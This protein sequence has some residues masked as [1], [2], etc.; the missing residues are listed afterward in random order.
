[1]LRIPA[2]FLMF[3]VIIGVSTAQEA[4]RFEP[5]AP[6]FA[7]PVYTRADSG[8]IVRLDGQPILRA[9]PFT[10]NTTNDTVDVSPGNGTCADSTGAC[11]L[12]AAIME[13]NAAATSAVISVPAGKYYLTRVS[14]TEAAHEFED[15]TFDLDITSSITL[16]GSDTGKT[17]II[18]G[19]SSR[20][21]H[22][23]A[24]SN[25]YNVEIMS[26][27]QANGN[28]GGVYVTGSGNLLMGTTY[29]HGNAAMYGAGAAVAGG[30]ILFLIKS[31]VLSNASTLG[32]GGIDAFGSTT[33]L[34]VYNSTIAQNGTVNQ[35]GGISVEGTATAIL[36][37]TSIGQNTVSS[38]SGSGGGLNVSAG[39]TAE[40]YNTG[41]G[42]NTANTNPDCAGAIVSNGSNAFE[43][44]SGCAGVHVND[45]VG[46]LRF[47]GPNYFTRNPYPMY[48][49]LPGS[50]L[51]DGGAAAYCQATDATGTPRPMNSTCD[52]GVY[53]YIV[54]GVGNNSFE[55]AGPSPKVPAFWTG[56]GLGSKD[57]RRCDLSSSNRA[58][59]GFCIFEFKGAPGKAARLIYPSAFVM[60]T[61][62][63]TL[64][65]SGAVRAKNA[66]VGG[67][68]IAKITYVGP[69]AGPNGN[70]K[71][72]LKV[73]IPAGTYAYQWLSVSKP[74]ADNI[75][76]LK[77]V[78]LYAGASG[79]VR[80][81]GVDFTAYTPIARDP[82]PLPVPPPLN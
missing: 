17:V 36:S 15:S 60:Q 22:V 16:N 31:S 8:E 82:G 33:Q 35:G 40:L 72:K 39:S 63:K 13:T 7:T 58:L 25:I 76:S 43:S 21:F 71:D 5:A 9:G 12:R 14:G 18:G 46:D 34:Y 68:L 70:G 80:V 3:L 56:S 47:T 53:E 29:I 19:G 27:Q 74:A 62:G 26:G 66:V 10:V 30:G 32:S 54:R 64:Y 28:G 65:L 61:A 44:A 51:I 73:A 55:Q 48:G 4:P 1:M 38:L 69:T 42:Y 77:V 11:S 24:F 2:G 79:T 49:L 41:I 81:D 37:N 67:K 45:Y 57:R 6:P 59:S 50:A 78:I 23:N 75:Q 20:V 52:I